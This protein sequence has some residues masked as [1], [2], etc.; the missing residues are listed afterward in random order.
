MGSHQCQVASLYKKIKEHFNCFVVFGWGKLYFF[1]LDLDN[2]GF[3]L[4]MCL[5]LVCT[6]HAQR[7]YSRFILRQNNHAEYQEIYEY[8]RQST[9]RVRD[10]L[11]W[12]GRCLTILYWWTI[13]RSSKKKNAI[14]KRFTS[15]AYNF[16]TFIWIFNRLGIP[17]LW[18]SGGIGIVHK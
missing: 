14:T 15:K 13:R 12:C 17:N 8:S 1:S 5:H 4:F 7:E 16:G 10:F 6:Q 11:C 2:A 9:H 18:K 3:S